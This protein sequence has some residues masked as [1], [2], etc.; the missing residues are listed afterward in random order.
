M[1]FEPAT[2]DTEVLRQSFELTLDPAF[3]AQPQAVEF[4]T[5][6]GL[7]AHGIFYQPAN[8][9]CEVPVGE[10]PPLIVMSHGGPTAAAASVLNYQIQFWTSRGFAV[11]DVNYGGSTGY[12]R[13]YRLR[14]NGQWGIVDV[15][16][17]CNGARWL[18]EQGWVDARR[19][20]IR[21]GSAGGFTTL[22]ALTFRAV[23]SAGASHFGV[24][25]LEALAKDTHKF[26]SRYL[27][28]LIG[29]YPARKDLYEA[30]SP[31]NHVDQL[32]TPL[33]LLQ[34]DEDPV[35]PPAQAEL[36]FEALRVKGVPVA[37]LLFEG[38]QHGFRKAANIQRALQAELFFYGK[39]FGFQPAEGI[40]PVPIWNLGSV[41]VSSISE[42]IR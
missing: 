18:A 19:M 32:T 41:A 27:D 25:D 2:G 24:S 21:G 5:E 38:E 20:A 12:G 42:S 9:D 39:I 37:Y 1:R 29:P 16:D 3:I 7:T 13:A 33:I 26:E 34:G 40:E 11:L 30:R 23:F 15:D 4:P 14:L 36:M 35:V 28:S 17:C 22:A 6:G 31:I 10:K 8:G